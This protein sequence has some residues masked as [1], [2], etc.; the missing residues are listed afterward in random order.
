MSVVS[1][2]STAGS[3]NL[4]TAIAEETGAVTIA[5]GQPRIESRGA[6]IGRIKASQSRTCKAWSSGSTATVTAG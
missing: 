4:D 3:V 5:A 2:R 6:T 1:L